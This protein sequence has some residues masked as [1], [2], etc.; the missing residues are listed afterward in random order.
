MRS[1]QGNIDARTQGTV[2]A[3]VRSLL[4]KQHRWANTRD[5]E[6]KLE[7][8]LSNIFLFTPERLE[9]LVI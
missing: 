7:E 6:G 9:H 2:S 1:L 5:G 8:S 4:G 3:T